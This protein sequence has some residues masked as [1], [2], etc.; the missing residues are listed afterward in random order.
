LW[1]RASIPDGPLGLDL[2]T[3]SP[4]VMMSARKKKISSVSG[5]VNANRKLSKELTYKRRDSYTTYKRRD[6]YTT[7]KRHDS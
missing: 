6:S 5:V 2:A 1:G 4:T 3:H 7:Y